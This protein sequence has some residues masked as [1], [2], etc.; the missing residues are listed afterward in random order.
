[1]DI[2][3]NRLRNEYEDRQVE[4]DTHRHTQTC[5]AYTQIHT[6]TIKQKRIHK[7]VCSLDRSTWTVPNPSS[8]YL[9][10]MT[11][12]ESNN[13]INVIDTEQ[14]HSIDDEDDDNG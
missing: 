7:H 10:R 11:V 1:M 13:I 3:I 2:D 6:Q 14:A 5:T 4:I 12:L 9:M 8:S